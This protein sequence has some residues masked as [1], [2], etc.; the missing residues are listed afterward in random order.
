MELHLP[1]SVTPNDHVK[2]DPVG[3][4]IFALVIRCAN[5]GD[6]FAM[7]VLWP[8][9]LIRSLRLTAKQIQQSSLR[10]RNN[11]PS[12]DVRSVLKL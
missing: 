5:P 7:V 4:G 6:H 3:K 10:R 12:F 1:R 8:L 11:P 9:A 2:E